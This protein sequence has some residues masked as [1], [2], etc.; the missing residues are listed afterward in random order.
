MNYS[1][2]FVIAPQNKGWILD[3]IAHEIGDRL[4]SATY[5]YDLSSI[6]QAD[7]YIIMHY[8]L[9]P[10]VFQSINP[11]A[12]PCTVFFTH[13]SSD[14]SQYVDSLNLCHSIIAENQASVDLLESRGLKSELLHFIPE[15]GD[16]KRFIPHD[17]TGRGQVLLAGAFYD[18][19][20]PN[21]IM[22]VVKH[23]PR[24]YT[25]IGKDWPRWQHFGELFDL[26]N[27]RYLEL[28][29]TGYAKV[30][31]ECD[32][33]LSCSTLEGGGPNSLIEAMHANLT[34]VASDTGNSNEYIQHGYN[35]FIFPINSSHEHVCDLIEKAYKLNT[36]MKPPYNDVWQ[37]VQDFNYDAYSK[38]WNEVF[39]GKYVND[40]V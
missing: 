22:E 40:T 11:V 36:K 34:P 8:S 1:I 28:D 9:A 35:G 12:K 30:Y 14:V 31:A 25:L 15:V 39:T 24:K 19:K 6:P 37:T 4:G 20:N 33:F 3:R 13:E 26:P 23:S 32:V 10:L 5:C 17:R 38:Q 21:L 2:C 29:Y 16:P 18:R 27:F 7:R